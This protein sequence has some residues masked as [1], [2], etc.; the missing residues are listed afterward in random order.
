[1]IGMLTGIT[2]P[3]LYTALGMPYFYTD[4]AVVYAGTSNF[5]FLMQ[6][7]IWRKHLVSVML[8][9]SANLSRN[10][11]LSVS[12]ASASSPGTSCYPQSI[13]ISFYE[14]YRAFNKGTVF[15]SF[16]INP[17]TNATALSVMS[18]GQAV[19]NANGILDSTFCATTLGRQVAMVTGAA[20][21]ISNNTILFTINTISLGIPANSG[22]L[23]GSLLFDPSPLISHI[24]DPSFFTSCQSSSTPILCLHYPTLSLFVTV[25]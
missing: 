3:S 2:S 13:N 18:C 22:E 25:W 16:A 23:V 4:T 19:A 21:D 20:N 12:Y 7:A 1:M 14:D 11:V 15:R 8:P 10:E 24:P 5:S 9:C 6:N 17:I